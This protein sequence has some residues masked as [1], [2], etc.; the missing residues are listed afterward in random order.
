MAVQ[1]QDGQPYLHGLYQ[2]LP[3]II[4][5]VLVLW[6]TFRTGEQFPMVQEQILPILLLI[7]LL[8][9]FFT[10]ELQHQQLMQHGL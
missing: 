5:R 4:S 9:M 10:M 3:F 7:I 8:I 2:E 6:I 1:L